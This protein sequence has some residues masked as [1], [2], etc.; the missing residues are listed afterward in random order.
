MTVPGLVL[1]VL[2]LF[3]SGESFLLQAISL[4]RLWGGPQDLTQRHLVRTVL[5]R[6]AMQLVY[7]GVG[8]ANL[9][10]HALLS[11]P[12]LIIFTTAALVWQ[13]NSLMDVRLRNRLNGT[14]PKIR[15][16]R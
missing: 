2:Y 6:V 11:I 16:P 5:S 9:V 7:V 12:A 1:S 15:R 10:T 3:V 14:N 4:I 8:I 13:I